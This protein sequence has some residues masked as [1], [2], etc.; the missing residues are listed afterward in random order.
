[1]NTS[2]TRLAG[3]LLLALA[4]A[5]TSSAIPIGGSIAINGTVELNPSGTNL[6]NSTG[7]DASTGSVTLASGAF[8]GTNGSSVAYSAFNWSPPSVNVNPLWSFTG[9]ANGWTYSFNLTSLTVHTHTNQFLNLSGIGTLTIVQNGFGPA[10]PYTTTAGSWTYQITSAN[11]EA[12]EGEFG[13]QSTNV[14]D[15]GMTAVLI[16]T[17]LL[18]VGILRRRKSA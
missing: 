6:G 14:P 17:A 8:A 16:G 7:A 2:I 4:V 15:G 11:G 1:M 18:G 10:S 12:I 9:G 13:F 5:G 3:A